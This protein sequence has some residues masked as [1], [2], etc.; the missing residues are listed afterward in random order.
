[1]WTLTTVQIGTFSICELN[2]VLYME[3]IYIYTHTYAYTIYIYHHIIHQACMYV[4][5]RRIYNIHSFPM[6]FSVS[7][8][9]KNFQHLNRYFCVQT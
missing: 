2:Y 7:I 1:M 9:E 3:Y 5:S 4:Y 6:R 8:K